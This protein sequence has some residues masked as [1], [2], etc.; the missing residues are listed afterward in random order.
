MR[1]F[2]AVLFSVWIR[3]LFNS[4]PILELAT[5]VLCYVMS[6]KTVLSLRCRN[7]LQSCIECDQVEDG[8]TIQK[9]LAIRRCIPVYLPAPNSNCWCRKLAVSRIYTKMLSGLQVGHRSNI[10]FYWRYPIFPNQCR[11]QSTSNSRPTH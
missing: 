6:K 1:I 2:N 10:A 5:I 7:P 8:K 3:W 11:P 9:Y 4:A